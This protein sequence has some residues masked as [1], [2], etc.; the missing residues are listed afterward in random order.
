MVKAIG[1]WAVALVS[2]VLLFRYDW[3]HQPGRDL[4]ESLWVVG[5]IFVLFWAIRM[6]IAVTRHERRIA[7]IEDGAGSGDHRPMR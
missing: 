1:F 7:K 2:V 3:H 5:F 4:R 6:T